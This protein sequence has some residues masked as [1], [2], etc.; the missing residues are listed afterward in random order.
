MEH[1]DESRGIDDVF[2]LRAGGV[3]GKSHQWPYAKDDCKLIITEQGRTTKAKA[4]CMIE[5]G[6][7]CRA[8]IVPWC[9]KGRSWMNE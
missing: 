7:P 1:I 2:V 5:H 8:K 6:N 3:C 4:V 9:F